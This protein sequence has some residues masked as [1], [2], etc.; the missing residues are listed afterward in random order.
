MQ[1][2]IFILLSFLF[3]IFSILLYFKL[4]TGRKEKLAMGICPVCGAEPKV[5]KDK[6]GNTFKT[7][8][9][10]SKLLKNHGCS[11]VIEVEYICNECG[12]KEVHAHTNG[13]CGI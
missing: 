10:K 12:N 1:T 4:K 6:F 11:G 3:V 9:I 2:L 13:G 8:V 5:F 7:D